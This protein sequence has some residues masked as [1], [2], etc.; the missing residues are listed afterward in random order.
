MVIFWDALKFKCLEVVLRSF[1]VKVKLKSEGEGSFWISLV[2]GPSSS[3]F[4]KDFWLELQDLSSLTF[5][6]WCVGGHFNVIRRI[7]EKLG[8]SRLT[9]S[10]RILMIL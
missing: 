1:Y 9:S 3:H 6:K 5:P 8:G 2:Y 4:R 10:M 7:L